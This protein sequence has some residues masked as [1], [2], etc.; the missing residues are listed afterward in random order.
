[1]PLSEENSLR[2]QNAYDQF[3]SATVMIDE[4]G[5]I[6]SCNQSWLSKMSEILPYPVDNYLG[7]NY[8]TILHEIPGTCTHNTRTIIHNLQQVLSQRTS[9]YIC[10]VSSIPNGSILWLRVEASPYKTKLLPNFK[11]LLISHYD[12]T[13]F[14]QLESHLSQA[15]SEIKT[16]RGML[17]IC[18]VC[19]RIRD[20]EDEWNP[21][22]SYV[23]RNT[24]AV[25]THDICPDCIRRLYP[26][27]SGFLDEN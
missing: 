2:P 6:F 24:H 18:A 21:V 7:M 9:G 27:Y 25:F 26:Q 17:P 10:E 3:H 4:E 8:Y 1:M 12:I 14:K 19:K 22:E 5:F 20:E 16:L 23:E 13:S 11:G 15:S